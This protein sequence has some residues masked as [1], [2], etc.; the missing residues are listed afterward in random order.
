MSLSI[1]GS[2]PTQAPDVA[3]A[4]TGELSPEERMLALM[5]YSQVSQMNEAKTSIDLNAQKLAELREE[6]RRALQEAMDAKKDAGFWGGLAKLFG[7]DL[8]SIAGAVAALAAVVA[9]GGTAAAILGAIAA[10]ASM[11]AEHADELG[12]PKGV[13]IAIAV[14]AAVAS[15]CCG[16]AG[17]LFKLSAEARETAMTVKT[18]AT[19]TAMALKAE[20][21]V[22]SVAASGYDRVSSY[23][24]ADAESADGKHELA[25]LDLDDSLSR[26]SAAF[27]RQGDAVTIASSI[28]RQNA[29]TQ[30]AILSNWGGAA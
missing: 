16:D 7:S 5:V 10:A 6:V 17:G 25:S 28:Q 11:A 2:S 20:G 18:Y 29:T 22:C 26:L 15:L 23:R 1:V 3:L 14:G 19:L 4:A 30:L 8:A 9:S 13:A 21:G 24:Q 27:D 12:L